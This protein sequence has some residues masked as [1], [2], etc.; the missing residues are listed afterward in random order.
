MSRSAPLLEEIGLTKSE[1]KVY[2]ALLELGSSTTGPIVD[3]SKASSSKIYEILEKLMQKGLAS[4]VIKSGTKYF[5][6]ADPKRLLDYMKEKENKLKKQEKELASLLPELQ[7]KRTL[8]KHKSEATIYKGMKGLETAFQDVLKTLKKGEINHAFI[9]GELDER[10]N[11]FFK[12]HYSLRGRKGI[13]TK[14]IFSEAGRKNYESRKHIP[15]FE[16]KVIGGTTSPA[17]VNVYGDKVNFRMG[18]SDDVIC[19]MIHDKKLA[20]SFKEHFELLWNQETRIVKGINAIKNLFEEILEA[21]HCDFI[22]AKDNYINLIP[23]H[24]DSWEKR[25]KKQG[26]SMRNIVD[27][28]TKGHRITHLPFAKTKY[29]IPKEFSAL[30]VFWI[31]SGKVAIGILVDNEPIVTIIENKNFYNLYKKQFE[32]LWKKKII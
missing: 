28:K 17:T 10:T 13:K 2:L 19:V 1:I 16:G 21:G 3:K 32:L 7:L 9:V 4:F 5:E 25:A 12:R 15:L 24:I 6:A 20:R 18:I 23:K 8:S 14:T 31:F 11:N 29:T 26:F 22:G 27:L 30:S